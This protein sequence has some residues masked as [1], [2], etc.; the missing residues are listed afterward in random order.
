M[1]KQHKHLEIY[2]SIIDTKKV[3]K[4]LEKVSSHDLYDVCKAFKSNVDNL[5]NVCFLPVSLSHEAVSQT[6]W[7]ERFRRSMQKGKLSGT[8][9]NQKAE[10]E[11]R[12]NELDHNDNASWT[13][14]V[15]D[16][17]IIRDEIKAG[18]TSLFNLAIINLWTIIETLSCDMWVAIVNANPETIGK[19][20]VEGK[21]ELLSKSLTN[22]LIENSFELSLKNNIG[23]VAS[24]AYNFSGTRDISRSFSIILNN[25][26]DSINEIFKK[27]ALIEVQALRNALVHNGGVID[28]AYCR[29]TE[30]NSKLGKTIEMTGKD[31]ARIAN[32]ALFICSEFILLIDSSIQQNA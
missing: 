2:A 5:A 31:V 14:S 11:K 22:L 32:E 30:N 18:I 15:L 20:A 16:E 7:I 12:M 4:E 6:E 26:R 1:T 25:Q 28:E 24:A 23:S 17:S 9:E 3:H 21:K 19:K 13:L 8:K 27:P 10:I 29:M